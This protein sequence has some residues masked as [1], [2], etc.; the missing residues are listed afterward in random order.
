MERPTEEHMKAVK[1]ILRYINGTLDYGLRYEKSTETTQLVGY[2]DSDHAGDIDNHKSTSGN[3]FY[4]GKCPV[5]WQSLKQRVVAL[6][7]CEAEY[8]AATTAATQAVWL[9]RLLVQHMGRKAE[10]VELMVDSKSALA[11]SK[12]PVFHERSKHIELRYHFICDYIEKGFIDANYINTKDQ[13]ADML[14]KALGRVKFQELRSRIRMIQ[15][16]S[17]KAHKA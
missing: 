7:S 8:V 15:I 11:L 1:R 14:T 5:S 10:C 4:L 13:L 2:S 3:L 6:S 12:N 16:P 17:S 9:A